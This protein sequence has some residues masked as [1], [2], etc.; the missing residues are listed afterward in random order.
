MTSITDQKIKERIDYMLKNDKNLTFI[1]TKIN[2]E[3]E[4]ILKKY[5]I[6]HTLNLV[7][8]TKI[9]HIALDGSDTGTGKTYTS[10]AVAKTLGLSPFIICPR[11][12]IAAWKLVC[13]LFGVTPLAI[14]NYEKIKKSGNQYLTVINNG[15]DYKWT[16]PNKTLV[17]F[18]EAHKCK[19]KKSQN[20]KLL[21]SLKKVRTKILLLS[22]TISDNPESFAV[23]GYM[24]NLYN[25][26]SY[27][28]SWIKSIMREDRKQFSITKKETGI[29]K[30]IYPEL[31]SRMEISEL[32]NMFPKNQISA[33]CYTLPASSKKKMA[34][35]LI[36]LKKNQICD[37]KK[38]S[39]MEEIHKIR[40]KIENLKLNIIKT[41]TGDYLSN[42]LS[43]AIFLNYTQNIKALSKM[44]GCDN[45]IYGEQS[46]EDRENIIN[47]FQSNESSVIICN[48][49]SSIGISLHDINY[50]QRVSLIS[51]NFSATDLV[52]ALGRIY[53]TDVK[54]PALQRIIY[55]ADTYEEDICKKLQNKL[56][57]LNKINDNDMSFF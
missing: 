29:N 25:T 4:K 35:Y 20:G 55:C 39:K 38:I 5:Q 26:V 11:P 53:R 7:V 30:L 49:K 40:S 2:P 31:G 23:F 19:N 15:K 51:P 27:G 43:I 47:S 9:N 57:F 3:A 16:L 32:A 45:L 14:V 34:D 46:Q 24:L 50:K 33:V 18:D 54:S 28:K 56:K 12:I 44:L 17:I 21:I 13:E 36:A 41:L 6:L 42:G 8:S 22:A 10:I 52:Q 37:V 48:I 1:K